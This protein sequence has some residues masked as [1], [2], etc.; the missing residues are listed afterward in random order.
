MATSVYN[1][2]YKSQNL[3][4]EGRF[5]GICNW[6]FRP[7]VHQINFVLLG[8]PQLIWRGN[9]KIVI[10]DILFMTAPVSI[11]LFLPSSNIPTRYPAMEKFN[12][13]SLKSRILKILSFCEPHREP[14]TTDGLP[15]TMHD[16]TWT[17]DTETQK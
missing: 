7:S 12:Y 1:N 13:V 6:C 5:K 11:F 2:D 4:Y 3:K 16:R 8:K 10:H 14:Q 15:K 17:K 9:T